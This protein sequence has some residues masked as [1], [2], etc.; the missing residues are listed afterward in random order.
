MWCKQKELLIKELVMFCFWNYRWVHWERQKKH[1]NY[2][3]ISLNI[4]D[5]LKSFFDSSILIMESSKSF[6]TFS[7]SRIVF[8][9]ELAFVRR[10]KFVLP[11]ASI[12]NLSASVFKTSIHLVTSS[13]FFP[14][15]WMSSSI[16]FR[17]LATVA[18]FSCFLVSSRA[19]L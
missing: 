16:N 2:K 12:D 1:R 4:N 11:P 15:T 10:S 18:I 13:F 14:A 19:A 5:Y 8:L 17:F 3:T 9:K 7:F 6:N